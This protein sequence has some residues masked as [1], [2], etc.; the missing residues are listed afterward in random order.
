MD[1]AC[2]A[3]SIVIV[4]R[5]NAPAVVVMSYEEFRGWK[6]TLHLLRS[7]ANAMRLLE[8]IADLDAGR[9]GRKKKKPLAAPRRPPPRYPTA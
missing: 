7:P 1:E 4:R 2:A 5:R 8:S 3:G 9:A 6:E